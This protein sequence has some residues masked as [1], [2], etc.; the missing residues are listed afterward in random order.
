M[1]ERVR[2]AGCFAAGERTEAGCR[3]SSEWKEETSKTIWKVFPEPCMCII[4]SFIRFKNE[5]IIFYCLPVLAGG[6]V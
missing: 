1:G 3:V 4:T 2:E 5:K 6:R